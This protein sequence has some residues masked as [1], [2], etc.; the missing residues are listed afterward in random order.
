MTDRSHNPLLAIGLPPRGLRREEAAAYIGVSASH[1]DELRR[2]GMMPSPKPLLGRKVWDRAQL[3]RA[4]A[5][6]PNEASAAGEEADP[7]S[8]LHV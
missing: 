5:A 4:F 1:F 8:D 2:R 7:W 3:D 6:L